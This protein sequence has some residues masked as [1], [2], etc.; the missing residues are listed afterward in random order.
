MRLVG[1]SLGM[2]L[3]GH[4]RALGVTLEMM[5]ARGAERALVV[6]DRPFGSYQDSAQAAF[7]NAARVMQESGCAAVKLED[8]FEMAETLSFP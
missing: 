3:Y 2:V 7:R 4:D 8:G 6:V 5:I 1:D